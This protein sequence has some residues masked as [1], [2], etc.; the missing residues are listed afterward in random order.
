MKR[1]RA[2]GVGVADKELKALP[3][4]IPGIGETL[5]ATLISEIGTLE[6]FSNAK[7][8][9]AYAGLDPKVRASG[10]SLNRNTKLTK[11]GSP[12]F[13]R[14]LYIGASISQRYDPDMKRYYEKKRAEGKRYKEATVANA[15]HLLARVYAV[16]KRGTPYE[17]KWGLSTARLFD[18]RL[19]V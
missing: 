4:S 3:V 9:V 10:K 6:R 16:W 19:Q 13:R 5:A 1:V 12:Y 11:R 17:R 8:L 18:A 7:A 14:A 2:L 15:R